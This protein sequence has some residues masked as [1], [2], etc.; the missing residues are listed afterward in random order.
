MYLSTGPRINIMVGYIYMEFVR[1]EW[2]H[3]YRKLPLYFVSLLIQ[4]HF[5]R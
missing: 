4:R 2:A 3:L 1:A 5:N